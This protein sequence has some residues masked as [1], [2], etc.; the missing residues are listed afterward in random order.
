M[1]LIVFM[2]ACDN[3]GSVQIS[4]TQS[5]NPP[6]AMAETDS[7]PIPTLDTGSEQETLSE[8]EV[9]GV[10]PNSND[11]DIGPTVT[12]EVEKEIVV[13]LAGSA[14]SLYPFGD[15]SIGAQ[16]LRH[17]IYE[18]LVTSVGYDYQARGLEKIPSLADGDASIQKAVVS[19]GDRVKDINGDVVSLVKDVV[20]INADGEEIKFDGSPLEMAQMVVDFH[21][22]PMIWSDGTP[23]T[24][25][26]SVYSFLLA[27][28]PQ[29]PLG[30][31]RITTTASYE[32]TDELSVR[33]SGIPG[34]R[35]QTY[36]LNVWQPL[37]SHQLSELNV[38]ELRLAEET[39]KFP[40]SSGP[41]VV[42]D[43]TDDDELVLIR[44]EQYY[45]LQKEP[46]N[47]D[48]IIVRFG[49]GEEFLAG[50]P[51]GSCDVI[52]TGAISTNN[53][54]L[55]EMAVEQGLWQILHSPGLVYEQISFGIDPVEEYA[56]RRPDW[57][58]DASVRQ[59]IA[60]CTDRQGM[61]DELTE[62]RA[63]LLHAYVSENHALFPNDLLRWNYDPDRA[64]N[65][66]DEAGFLDLD[67]DG[68][69]QDLDSGIPMT[70]TLG[71]NSESS[72]RIQVTNM[73]KDDLAG[74]GIPVEVYD[75]P[76]G[77]WFA[78]G[79][80][81]R[82]FGR[83]FDLAQFAWVGKLSPICSLYLSDNITGPPD[84]GFNGWQNT[85]VS[86]WS[87]EEFD[88]A[89]LAAREIMPGGVGYE[90][91][92][93]EALRIFAQ[94]LPALPLFSNVKVAAIRPWMKNVRLDPSQ[95]SILWNIYEWD[96]EQ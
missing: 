14:A 69:R 15:D 66:L 41:Y 75:Y 56:G 62:G 47:L 18:D 28:D 74:C 8:V 38:A 89:C 93:Q 1:L 45:R 37:P 40:L 58:E 24:A 39:N 51:E 79:P 6:A 3:A 49:H 88:F 29:T 68:W 48:R 16:G 90:A 46:P 54:P 32:A 78:D 70:I 84:A 72:L 63:E 67:E 60:L 85:N 12:P 2:S 83:R 26:D 77:T 81:G 44:N 59:A 13:C 43:W 34:H 30:K 55:L 73:V 87:D 25:H 61:V 64:N 50:D 36:F 9:E 22:Q 27:S 4:P 10:E 17:A 35:D 92:Q 53:L 19:E 33:W 95:R 65:L 57:F 80:E 11:L 96:I 94:Q 7:A 71:T 20:V 31:D 52:S 42:V 86:G 23:V 82:V 91:S 76:A 21:F 5:A